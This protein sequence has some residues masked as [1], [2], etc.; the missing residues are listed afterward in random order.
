MNLGIAMELRVQ[1]L[2][3]SMFGW[4]RFVVYHY[5]G[6]DR[7]SSGFIVCYG[8]YKYLLPRLDTFYAFILVTYI[9]LYHF[10]RNFC[11]LTKT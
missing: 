11:P 9:E 1:V 7:G 6:L 2:A 8:V 10:W 3:L 4:L 5:N